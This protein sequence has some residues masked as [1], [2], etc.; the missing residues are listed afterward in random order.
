MTTEGQ[1]STPLTQEQ[2]LG[3]LQTRG[4]E[5]GFQTT[6]LRDF[7]GTLTSITGDM[8]TGQR[9][10]FAVALYNF[11][12]VDVIHAT[13][14]YTNTVAQIEIPLSGRDKSRM[15]Y[16]GDSVDDIINAGIDKTLPQNAPNVRNQNFLIGKRIHLAM[17]PGHPIPARNDT[18]GR[19]EDRPVDCW[20][21]LEVEG[22]AAGVAP[23]APTGATPAQ[24]TTGTTSVDAY[25]VALTLLVGKTLQ[26]WHQEVFAHPAIKSNPALINQIISGEFIG[27]LEAAGT[28]VKDANG[29]YQLAELPF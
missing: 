12:D 19:W 6:P 22:L 11:D 18:T 28:V 26:Q 15:G 3:M 1:Q 29:A 9:G 5:A 24:P 17:T 20:V 16:W 4:F 25:Q 7:W 14:P 23:Q 27:G 8:R 13:E 2:I 10:G 21:L